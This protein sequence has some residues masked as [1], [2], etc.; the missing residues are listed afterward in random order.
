MFDYQGKITRHKKKT[1]KNFLKLAQ[2]LE[3]DMAGIFEIISP[4]I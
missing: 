3:L 4:G 1:I 2:A